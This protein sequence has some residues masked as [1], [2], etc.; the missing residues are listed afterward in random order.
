MENTSGWRAIWKTLQVML[1]LIDEERR[2]KCISDLKFTHYN[3][4]HPS[5]D[6]PCPLNKHFDSLSNCSEIQRTS[7]RLS[8][9]FEQQLRK[10]GKNSRGAAEC[11]II[12]DL[13]SARFVTHLFYETLYA[14][15]RYIFL[16]L[17]KILWKVSSVCL[18]P[19]GVNFN[20]FFRPRPRHFVFLSE[21]L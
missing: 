11:F 3:L 5:L 8:Y 12:R 17:I 7:W 15:S 21:I 19:K 20:E 14:L 16:S 2:L 13:L 10:Y 4:S 9:S 1:P 6:F 18:S